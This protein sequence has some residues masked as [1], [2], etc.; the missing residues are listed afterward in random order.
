[1]CYRCTMYFILVHISRISLSMPLRGYLILWHS[2][3]LAIDVLEQ[4]KNNEPYYIF[5]LLSTRKSCGN[6]SLAFKKYQVYSNPKFFRNVHIMSIKQTTG[7]Y[8]I[9]ELRAVLCL[10][11]LDTVIWIYHVETVLTDWHIVMKNIWNYIDTM[12]F[13]VGNY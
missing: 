2:Y 6:K 8:W 10:L 4:E 11:I 7:D 1:M 12:E 5:A 9:I 3:L 13:L